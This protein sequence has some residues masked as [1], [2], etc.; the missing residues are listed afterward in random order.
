VTAF[1]LW[2]AF[3]AKAAPRTLIRIIRTLTKEN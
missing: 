1:L 3:L 2:P